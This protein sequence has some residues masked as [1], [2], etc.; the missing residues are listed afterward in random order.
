M[1]DNRNMHGVGAEG[2]ACDEHMYEA[3]ETYEWDRVWI[4]HAPDKTTKRVLYIGDSISEAT[5]GVLARM[6]GESVRVDGYATSKSIDNPCF[7]DAVSLLSRQLSRTDVVLFNN[8]LHGWHLDPETYGFFYRKMIQFLLEK[9]SDSRI[10]IVLTT[11]VTASA[12][13]DG[14]VAR[15]QVA[16]S[17][18]N[19][20]HL[21][22]IDLYSVTKEHRELISKDRIHLTIGGTELIAERILNAL[23]KDAPEKQT[24]KR[25][26]D[27]VWG[28][29]I[30]DLKKSCLHVL[31][32]ITQQRE[33]A[34]G[35]VKKIEPV[36]LP[37]YDK[38]PSIWVRDVAMN[39]EC[40]LIDADLL[41]KHILYFATYAQNGDRELQL[42][43]HLVV[44]AWTVADHLN[45]NG[46]PVYFP[47]TYAD[48]NDQ[49]DGSFGYYPS[50]DDNYYLVHMTHVYM[51][52]TGDYGILD[53]VCSGMTLWERLEKAWEGYHIDQET[54]LCYSRMP[55]YTV[56]WGFTDTVVKSGS[57][58]FSSLLRYQAA[59][60]LAD[61]CTKQGAHKKAEYYAARAE[62]VKNSIIKTFWDGS[63][64]LYSATGLCH[65]YD[66]WGTI[67][68]IYI[69]ILPSTLEKQAV[70]TV[71]QAYRDGHISSFGYV[72][73]IRTVDDD[74]F[75][76]S[77]EAPAVNYTK[78]GQY[79]NGGYWAS[80]SGWL[81]YALAK[82]NPDLAGECID[83]FIQHTK[84]YR[85]EGAPFE[86]IN[87]SSTLWEG[88]LAGSCATLPYAGAKRIM[89]E[90][91]SEE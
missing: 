27:A 83:A 53:E 65:Q 6:Y 8:G 78:P 30:T 74:A 10:F 76:Q 88:K 4:D 68:A 67:Y 38:Y 36:L 35:G 16:E 18:A 71:A 75:G 54:D 1:S 72:R 34:F 82:S 63:G 11:Y 91:F 52:Q 80:A 57:L 56:D 31:E 89:T 51:K 5:R 28:D 84:Q 14:V 77:W 42:E 47:G 44:P 33:T 13:M 39:A 50:L 20:Y 22:V 64:W 62:K 58:L 46:R 48:G 25:K 43:H 70:K 15:N 66:V 19:E 79:Q 3:Y 9:F 12:R 85:K 55:L 69:G 86:F 37:T 40:G 24:K 23:T 87:L 26:A 21:P 73:M 7:A 29:R 49:G 61:A 41:K 32:A 90:F 2:A 59:V 60:E 81:F 17:I 45:Y